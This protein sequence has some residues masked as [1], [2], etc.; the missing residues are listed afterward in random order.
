M[1]RYPLTQPQLGIYLAENNAAQGADYNIALVYY[2]DADI[3]TNRL[4][5]ALSDTLN[6]H[7]YLKARLEQEEDGQLYLVAHNNDPVIIQEKTVRN[8]EEALQQIGSRFNLLHDNLYRFVIYTFGNGQRMLYMDFHHILCDG[9]SCT[10]F[11]Q[12]VSE[13]YDEL[14]IKNYELRERGEAREAREAEYYG[15]EVA[16]KEEN[17]R[18][19]TDILQADKNW[20]AK[21]FGG[22][23]DSG[24]EAGLK[25]DKETSDT[26]TDEW[27]T[28]FLPIEVDEQTVEICCT[29]AAV[30]ISIPFTAALGYTLASY[31]ASTEALFATIWHGRTD[32]THTEAM[33][34]FVK[35][36]PVYMRFA[37][38]DSIYLL[39]R[40]KQ[41]LHDARAHSL[42]SFAEVCSDL[43]IH[44]Q[45]CFAYH[46]NLHIY[47]L[48]LDGKEQRDEFV[49]HHRPGLELIVNLIKEEHGY[50]IKIEY[51]RK[52]YTEAFI[53]QFCTTYEQVLHGILEGQPLE[54]IELVKERPELPSVHRTDKQ[55]TIVHLFRQTAQAY[56]DN[57]AVIYR[58]KELSY[59]ELDELSDKMA[60]EILR[61]CRKPSVAAIL[62]GRS[63]QMVVCALGALKAG[64]AYQ[65][66]DPGYP[67]ERLNFMVKDSGAEVLLCEPSLR[68]LL[69]DYEEEEGEI[70]DLGFGICDSSKEQGARNKEQG[71][72]SKE[73]G[74]RN[75]EQGQGTGE[76]PFILL[77]TSG[78]TGTPKGVQLSHHNLVTFCDWYR[79]YYRL[80]PEHRVAAYASFGFDADMMDLYPA[81]TTGAAVVIVPEDLRI[82]LEAL[83]HYL[84]DKGV[85][86]SFMTTQ[87]GY[88]FA[89]A[90]PTHP[91][92]QHLTVGGEKL[93]SLEPPTSYTLHNAYGPTECTIFSTIY[94]VSHNERNI[95]I[96]K[97]LDTFHA[98]VVNRFGKVLPWGAAGELIMCGEQVGSGYL[99]QPE[100]TEQAFI[101]FAGERAYRT[102]DIVRYRQNGDI[103][104][105]GRQDGQVKI[106]GF[107]IE[108]K[109]VEAVIR[110][111]DG[112]KDCTVQAFDQESGG[113][114]IAAYIVADTTIDIGQLNAFIAA[115]KP[116]YMVPA[117]T[118]QIDTIPLNINQK[119]DKKRLPKPKAESQ[120]SAGAK[121]ESQK[122]ESELN[123][124]EKQLCAMVNGLTQQTPTLNDPLIYCG[125]NSILAMRL[126]VMLYKQFGVKMSGKQILDGTTLLTIENAILEEV[127]SGQKSAGSGQKSAGSGQKSAGKGQMRGPLSFAQEGVFADC[128]KNPRTTIYNIPMDICLPATLAPEHVRE[129]IRQVLALHP[130]LF[131]RFEEN[132]EGDIIQSCPEQPT[133]AV[134]LILDQPLESVKATF[135]QP[136]DLH[137]DVL[138]RCAVVKS[139]DTIH[140][141][142]DA[143]HLV[144]DGASFDVIMHELI[145]VLHGTKPTGENCP[146]VRFA[147][148]QRAQDEQG[149][150]EQH[151]QFFAG[152]L[153]E[154]EETSVPAADLPAGKTGHICEI[155]RPINGCQRTTNQPAEGVTD[156][157]FWFSVIAYTLARYV[158]TKDVYITT[159]SNGRQ[160]PAVADTIGM[161]VNT[162]PVV[163]HLRE[164]T[165]AEFLTATARDFHATIQHENYPFSRIAADYGYTADI[166]YAYQLG[167]IANNTVDGQPVTIQSFGLD[168]PKFKLGIY[169]EMYQGAPSLVLQYDDA[170]YSA[171]HMNR[172][173]DSIMAVANRF[174][175]DASQPL[176]HVSIMTENQAQEA[177]RFSHVADMDVSVQ[178]FHEGISRWATLTPDAT[179]VIADDATLTYRQY[180]DAA[181][182]MAQCLMEKGVA[183]GDRIVLL[184]PRTSDFLI[185]VL[186]VMKCGAA[187]IPMDPQYP[188]DRIAYILD[189]SQGRFVIT[190]GEHLSDYPNRALDIRELRSKDEQPTN[191]QTYKCT[192]CN[193]G[194]DDLA[195]LIYT[196]GSTGTPKGVMLQHKGICNYLT[197]HPANP[198]TYA[199]A[200]EAKA[201]LCSATVS[202]DL[203]ILE[204]GTAL[205]NGKTVV[206][207]NEKATTDSALLARLYRQTGADVLSGTPSRIETY[208]EMDEYRQVVKQCK[209]IQMGGEKLPLSLLKRLQELTKAKI[210]N[211][212]GPTEIT[213][214]C[215]AQQLNDCEEVT[216]GKPL[217]NFTEQIV[218]ADGNPLPVGV[219]GELIV[220]GTGVCPGYNNLP[221]KTKEAFIHR[222]TAQERYYRT[223]DYAKWNSDGD[224]IILGRT[225]HQ[226]KLNGLRIELGEIE[227]VMAQS[228]AVKQCVVQVRKVGKQD[229]LVAYYVAADN[230]KPE[231]GNQKQEEEIKAAMAEHLTHYMVPNIFVRLDRFPITPAGKIDLKHLPEPKIET[232]ASYVAPQ[233]ETEKDFCDIFAH[234]LQT[235]KVGAEDD[236]FALG[237]TS[238]VAIKVVIAASKKQYEITYS[239]VFAN[240]TPRL[241]AAFASANTTNPTN[242][243]NTTNENTP[244]NENNAQSANDE[245]APLLKQ[246]TLS[247]FLE[248]ERQP[249]GTVLLTGATGYL[250]IHVLYRLLTETDVTVYCPVRSKDN[251][252]PEERLR[253]LLFYYFE[254]TF[255]ELIGKRLFVTEGEVTQREWMEGLNIPAETVINCLAN[256]KHFSTGNDIEFVNVE[257]VRNL[258]VWCCKSGARLVHISTTSV[259]GRSVNGQPEPSHIYTEQEFNIGQTLDNQYAKAKYE[260]E[261]LVLDSILHHGLNAKIL[262]VGNLSARCTDGEFQI[263][264]QS[265]N[266]MATIR[267]YRTLG[268]CPYELLDAPC[269]FSPIDEVADAVLRLATTPKACVIF[270]PTN[271]HKQ[272]IG[273][274]LRE[275][276]IPQAIRPIE[277]NEFAVIMQEALSDEQLAVKLRPLM[278]YKQK[279]NKAPISIQATNA[280][281]TQV[282]HRLGFHWSVTSWDYVRRFLQAIAGMGYFD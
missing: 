246:N 242:E 204:Y 60:A 40:L 183:K 15:F 193:V 91:T 169:V 98:Y 112:I 236:F 222:G 181:N 162:L 228:P 102:G 281:T 85:S 185:A 157:T 52:T 175:Q 74:A 57:A 94:P 280:Y 99:N 30:G 179:A 180:D 149:E 153:A 80:R 194:G 154:M 68:Q 131:A 120:K 272:L 165:V 177:E 96:G 207:A 16:E 276:N 247:A 62:V 46:A 224:V 241:L 116:A 79:R 118:M 270:H 76:M 44:P 133:P 101:H 37:A 41:Q 163:A 103:E 141:L 200:T 151:R 234:V 191:V 121:V 42:Y 128:L 248:G 53:R 264:F 161:F 132:E 126:S 49:R 223:G 9:M 277:A 72:R 273:D 56:P 257:S 23:A 238:L 48:V 67:A 95:P 71:A 178:T 105:V 198:H 274:V 117:I 215:N 214:C 86:H 1:K 82:D 84:A 271:P 97:P 251:T 269:E 249:L 43:D 110:A 262:R 206:F 158:N 250:G 138:H 108:L 89:V 278:A 139:E 233:T 88:Q 197:P 189:D 259:A 144:A 129:A 199:V 77:Y 54:Q 171:E 100:K 3:E 168:T 140:V 218:D 275:M 2:L 69:T 188:A 156:A 65:P 45:V 195:Y 219:M 155:A 18:S 143:H 209:V 24:N 244:T 123:V 174:I 51:N 63:E 38:G 134:Q 35:T 205:F 29:R 239:D 261:K 267:A 190:T 256:V 203:S 201:V 73:Q 33:G 5:Q 64:C 220:S 14:R 28:D 130:M 90:Y 227:T 192:N 208:L 212:Y 17:L 226:V 216:V 78:S 104:F 32:K 258:I 150:M 22:A 127:I 109:E 31:N 260:A 58:D 111:F 137:K 55:E 135:V 265:N 166:T 176:L 147:Q 170:V 10:T 196:S 92:L 114:Y 81:L 217:P 93:A 252:S 164:Q 145:D 124:L 232:A 237:G 119:V 202:F 25:G 75:K 39:Q 6:H 4:K 142:L 83:N 230:P 221:D 122:S 70:C 159:V 27:V 167:I 211:M 255:D 182:S 279:G 231:A 253:I 66:L 36:L 187:Y 136:F 7:P 19:T 186:A 282:L 268:V 245:F 26:E 240:P 13:R 152:Q 235:D 50:Q 106:R 61:R 243:N 115:Q 225:D 146:Y 229:K 87:V 184:L 113:K 21:E 172:L 254:R 213:I 12:E 34:M 47:H 125:I 8:R 173:A 107:R 148:E 266:F 160:D 20:Y 59:R 263:N 11:H 210:Y